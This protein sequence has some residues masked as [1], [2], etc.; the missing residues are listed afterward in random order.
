MP[1]RKAGAEILDEINTE[2]NRPLGRAPGKMPQNRTKAIEKLQ[3]QFQF[4]DN[5]EL[6]RHIAMQK[7]LSEKAATE[8]VMDDKTRRQLKYK[9]GIV[10]NHQQH[11]DAKHGVKNSEITSKLKKPSDMKHVQ[12]AQDAELEDL[13][14][15]VVDEIEDRQAH[16]ETLGD[17]CDKETKERIKHEIAERVGE[18]QR[19]RE[20]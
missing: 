18:L 6:E 2:K 9:Q 17:N 11:W 15:S 5:A 16:L 3:D 13:F 19:I 20:L 4:K 1:R 14:M 10:Q 8:Y 7:A 12:S